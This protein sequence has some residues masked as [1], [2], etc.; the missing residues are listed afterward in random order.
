MELSKISNVNSGGIQYQ[1]L[2]SIKTNVPADKKIK[3]ELRHCTVHNRN[4]R[5]RRDHK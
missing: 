2:S 3:N 5:K 4:Q 1:L